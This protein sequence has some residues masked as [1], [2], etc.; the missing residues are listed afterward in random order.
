MKN[1]IVLNEIKKELNSKLI[2]LLI[3]AR[4][5]WKTTI[6]K[7]I[8][9]HQTKNNKKTYFLNLEDRLILE[10][11]NKHPNKLFEITGS[12]YKEKQ[13]IFIDE[14]QYLDNPTN[15]LKYIYDEYKDNIK[16]IV[17]WSSSFYIDKKFKDSLVWRKKIFNI[18]TL[19]FFEFLEFKNEIKLQKICLESKNIPDLFRDEIYNLFLEYITYWW[20][21]EIVLIKDKKEKVERLKDYCFDYIKKDIYEA[22]IEN[23]NKFLNLLKILSTQTWELVNINELANT[24]NLSFQTVEKYLYIMQKSFFI[25]LIKP[26]HTNIRKE[27]TK[28]PKIYFYDLGIR[29]CFLNDFSNIIDRLDK[30]AYLENIVFREFLFK[31]RNDFFI[32]FW[33][34]QQKNEV[35]FI[36]DEKEAYEIK[37]SKNQIN[38]NKYKIFK[39]KYPNL[40]IKFITFSNIFENIFL[41]K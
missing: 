20:Y 19:D 5:V 12:S 14:I 27:L 25:S 16:L 7:A 4:Q 10:K 8:E 39:S 13:I 24:L 1:R 33:R 36:L 11:L 22:N 18:Y 23:Q 21:P 41:K 37:F 38:E 15:F 35:D 40:D 2:I 3:W 6:L 31:Y 29:N 26:F 28:M 17:T 9:K 34:T 30:W 32:K